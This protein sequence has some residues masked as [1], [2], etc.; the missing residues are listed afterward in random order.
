ML[1]RKYPDAIERATKVLEEHA[2]GTRVVSWPTLYHALETMFLATPLEA[3]QRLIA[4]KLGLLPADNPTAVVYRFWWL[5]LYADQWMGVEVNKDQ[6]SFLRADD[7]LLSGAASAT[8][9]GQLDSYVEYA[10]KSRQLCESLKAVD[11]EAQDVKVTDLAAYA[12]LAVASVR[13]R[14]WL[15]SKNENSLG[16]ALEALGEAADPL[17]NPSV[18]T[19]PSGRSRASL[20]ELAWSIHMW[21]GAAAETRAENEPAKSAARTAIA[22]TAAG[23]L[24]AFQKNCKLPSGYKRAISDLAKSLKSLE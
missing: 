5:M 19:F 12:A 21:Y 17:K 18:V 11:L 3:R 16:V 7:P 2:S 15:T 4:E 24:E 23:K 13:Y 22:R 9:E 10:E 1:Q 6:K 20:E 14:Q 8:V